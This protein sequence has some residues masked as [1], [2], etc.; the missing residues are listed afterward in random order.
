MSIRKVTIDVT[1]KAVGKYEARSYPQDWR[2]DPEQI[3]LYSVPLYQILVSGTDDSGAEQTY[4]FS[5][6]RFMPYW[7][8]PA[9][10]DKHYATRGWV[11]AGLSKTRT[12]T[13]S[14]YLPNY[15]V[16]NRYSPGRGAI[17]LVGSF[18]IHAGPGEVSDFGFGSAGCIEIVGNYDDFKSS[19]GG[20]SG[21]VAKDADRA[22]EDLVKHRKLVVQIRQVSVPDIKAAYTRKVARKVLFP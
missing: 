20:L 4:E 11:N 5:A 21:S 14:R 9:D 8:D 10:P 22:I 17:V 7:N 3:E 6:P 18:Y 1:G 16:Q 12:I 13:V 19:I 15:K 2:S